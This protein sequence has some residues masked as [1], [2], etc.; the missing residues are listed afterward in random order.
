M[1][2]QP[3]TASLCLAHA[4]TKCSPEDNCQVCRTKFTPVHVD[5]IQT[6][7]SGIHGLGLFLQSPN[8]IEEDTVVMLVKGKTFRK[9]PNKA[10]S[11]TIQVGNAYVEPS[12]P[13]RFVNHCCQPNARF[14]KWSAAYGE[15]EHVAIVSNTRLSPGEEITVSYNNP[16]NFVDVCKCGVVACRKEMTRY[17]CMLEAM[18][19]AAPVERSLLT[20]I[21]IQHIR[22][23]EDCSTL[24]VW[25]LND[26]AYYVERSTNRMDLIARKRECLWMMYPLTRDRSKG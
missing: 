14:Q 3:A 19:A 16:N 4:W 22:M 9:D 17:K 21:F 8:A 7:T 5:H 1:C 13:A 18:K 26:D 10:T 2:H 15:Q 6:K 23:D 20:L 11:F 24:P 25:L 12:A